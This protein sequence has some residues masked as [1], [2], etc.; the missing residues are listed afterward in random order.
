M[1]EARIKRLKNKIQ[2]S[3]SRL[4]TEHP[5]FA[6]LLMYVRF[7]A[8]PDM[9]KM[10]TNGRCIFFSPDFMDKLYEYELDYILCHQ[11]LHIVTGNIWRTQDLAG[12][13]Y[14]FACDILINNLLS[15]QFSEK[16]KYAHL[17]EIHLKIP[18]NCMDV[19][20]LTPNEVFSLIPFSLYMFED[21]TR[22]RFLPDND[23]YWDRKSDYGQN[24]ILILD[25]P[26]LNG[27]LRQKD[28]TDN[29]GGLS[30]NGDAADNNEGSCLSQN[31]I[32]GLK[33]EWQ[34]RV[35]MALKAFSASGIN[36]EFGDEALLIERSIEKLRHPVVNWKKLLN[37]FIQEC[38][39][40]YSFSPPDRRYE[41]T[42]F[43]LPD[44]NE[45]EFVSKGILFMA[46]ASGSVCVDSLTDV[47]SEIKGAIEQFGGKLEGKLGFFD[48]EVS[49]P[50]PFESVSDLMSIVPH[51]GGG[52]D[53]CK[54]F[55]Y[56]AYDYREELPSCIVIFT[57]GYGPY[58][59]ESAA[60]GI[61]VLWIIDN[62]ET[63]PPWGKTTRLLSA[64]ADEE[65]SG[66]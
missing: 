12:D 62:M 59:S 48:T 19:S 43:F 34:N 13:N 31:G 61:P 18:G 54:I 28:F 56:L 5:V 50:V 60:L 27:F 64:Y 8:V 52:T 32:D 10:S 1:T 14:H 58:P 66:T 29:N 26:D 3:R 33:R 2:A 35:H 55:E 11:I 22:S 44:F 30:C 9:K 47:F 51:G 15:G 49:P 36:K 46:D 57:D 45:K 4:M 25:T 24:G 17:G 39:F 40:D 20:K 63:T 65:K 38:T 16:D 23:S 53:F 41:D 42:G 21:R 7:I 6:L 37:E